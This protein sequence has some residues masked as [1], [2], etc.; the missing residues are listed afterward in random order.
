MSRGDLSGGWRDRL[1]ALRN[2]L[3]RHPFLYR[4]RYALIL[5]IGGDEI[6]RRPSPTSRSD[7]PRSFAERVS[8]IDDD[9][10]GSFATAR[11]IAYD[12]SA[13]HRRG[14]GLGV[15]SVRALERVYA[16]G[17]GVCSDYTQVFLGLMAAAGLTA[18][19]WGLCESFEGRGVGHAMTEVW[20]GEFDKWVFL[21]PFYS[22]YAVAGGDGVPLSVTEIV[23]LATADRT[24]EIRLRD[25]DPEGSAGERR[26][27]YVERY[28]E[29][30]R[31][32]F[33]LVGN[34]VF[35][36]DRFLRHVGRVPIP[37]LHFAMILR[38]TYQRFHLYTNAR[39][40]RRT[41]RRVAALR[42]WMAAVAASGAVLAA[43]T[44][45]GLVAFLR[46]MW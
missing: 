28:F 39:N 27:R 31:H 12:L 16:G 40:R 22:L 23:D 44:V 41:L 11:R 14:P 42:Q 4:F 34:D 6:F 8:G 20:A 7:V 3:K 1:A 37:L 35:R 30:R 13:G 15:D 24:E 18:R 25:V 45:L 38:G 9:D 21:D 36:Q 19:E 17:A 46:A 43:V 10:A 5:R 2:R 26:Q 32:F 29:G 33:L